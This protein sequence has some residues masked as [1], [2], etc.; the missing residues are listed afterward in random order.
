MP[1]FVCSCAVTWFLGMLIPGKWHSRDESLNS[2]VSIETL[3]FARVSTFTCVI[4]VG[5]LAEARRGRGDHWLDPADDGTPSPPADD[6]HSGQW[7]TQNGRGKGTGE[8]DRGSATAIV[9]RCWTIGRHC[10]RSAHLMSAL[11]RLWTVIFLVSYI[12][13]GWSGRICT[14]GPTQWHNYGCQLMAAETSVPSAPY[15]L[16]MPLCF[17][18]RHRRPCVWYAG[19]GRCE[20]TSD[21][22]IASAERPVTIIPLAISLLSGGR[23]RLDS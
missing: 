13:A 10:G 17:V 3:D 5:S 23:V 18:S 15:C 22:L 16:D 20:A 4:G 7:R 21:R 19:H 1:V 8:R 6:R 14:A 2:R 12:E 9:G 11:T